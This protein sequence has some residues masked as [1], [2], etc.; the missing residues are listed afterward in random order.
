MKHFVETVHTQLIKVRNENV[1]DFYKSNIDAE[2]RIM[3]QSG[4]RLV[5]N[6]IDELHQSYF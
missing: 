6:A 5:K 4:K 1:L 3:E 2:E